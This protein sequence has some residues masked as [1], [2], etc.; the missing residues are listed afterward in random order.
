MGPY[1]RGFVSELGRA[2]RDIPRRPGKGHPTPSTL[3]KGEITKRPR[4]P[5]V[6]G[7]THN[8]PQNVAGAGH[9]AG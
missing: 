4:A 6:A 7:H 5:A 9:G 3:R 1:V 8:T 2:A